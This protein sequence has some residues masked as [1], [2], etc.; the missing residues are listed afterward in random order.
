MSETMTVVDR[1]ARLE[2]FQYSGPS[3]RRGVDDALVDY[4]R[5]ARWEG[6][7]V[8]CEHYLL[9]AELR[10]NIITREQFIARDSWTKHGGTA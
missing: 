7:G 4:R 5:L 1:V 2:P 9:K 3:Y 10:A 8:R 6:N